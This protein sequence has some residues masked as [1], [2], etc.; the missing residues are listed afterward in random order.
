MGV[1][2]D[3]IRNRHYESRLIIAVADTGIGMNDEQVSRVFEEFQ[4]AGDTTSRKYGGT[5]LGLPISEQLAQLLGGDYT[6]TS[7]QGE[8]SIF[9]LAMPLRYTAT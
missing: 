7:V 6:A 8:G 3:A 5:G 9:T 1:S 2:E 4:Q